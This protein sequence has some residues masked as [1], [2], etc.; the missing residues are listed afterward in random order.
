MVHHSLH[1]TLLPKNKASVLK[2]LKQC[3]LRPFTPLLLSLILIVLPAQQAL[4]ANNILIL[5]DSLSAAYGIDEE[6]GW[7]ALLQNKLNVETAISDNPYTVINASISGETSAGGLRRLPELNEQYSPVLV[8]IELGGND[9]LRGYPLQRMKKNLQ[10]MIDN[11]KEIT[12]Q[13]LLLGM[14]I[15]PNYGQRYSRQFAEV[16]QQLKNENGIMLVDF[17]LDNVAIKP[18]LMQKDGI[19]PTAEGQPIMLDN[20]WPA[21]NEALKK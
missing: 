14:Q 2:L 11:S 3:V 10:M 18:S 9:G 20:V 8:V 17:F 7:V 12:A 1:T 21:I 5:G 13:V 16:Y 19:H 15:P 4:A 6:Q